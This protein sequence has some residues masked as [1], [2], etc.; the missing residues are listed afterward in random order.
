MAAR[1]S[2]RRRE[3][4]DY[5]RRLSLLGPIRTIGA[6]YGAVD[7]N[8]RTRAGHFVAYV[9]F[10]AA[11]TTAL[12]LGFLDFGGVMAATGQSDLTLHTAALEA[13]H[14]CA[15]YRAAL[16]CRK[17]HAHRGDRP[18]SLAL[19]LGAVCGFDQGV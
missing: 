4:F 8:Q 5:V 9:T 18:T 14:H 19:R 1:P 7:V 11:V 3:H 15:G 16:R 13:A 2:V 12:A 10:L 17:V 6:R